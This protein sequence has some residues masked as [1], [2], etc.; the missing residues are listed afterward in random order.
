[1]PCVLNPA[2]SQ[3][4]QPCVDGN[5]SVRTTQWQLA[6]I[7]VRRLL[8]LLCPIFTLKCPDEFRE[9]TVPDQTRCLDHLGSRV[10]AKIVA[11]VVDHVGR[12]SR[13]I[14]SL[15][16]ASSA[17]LRHWSWSSSSSSLMWCDN[18]WVK[19]VLSR[20]G[21]RFG[22]APVD[23]CHGVASSLVPARHSLALLLWW[24]SYVE[25]GSTSQQLIVNKK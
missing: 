8:Q 22:S 5:T 10:T 20:P 7:S 12:A 6:V 23:C 16:K 2:R 15:A 24:Q 4:K 1:M 11:S 19:L 21:R 3:R 18:I 13:A 17:S 25:N 14:S 9:V